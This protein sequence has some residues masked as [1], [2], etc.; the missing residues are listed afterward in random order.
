MT[1]ICEPNL[2]PAAF[3]GTRFDSH[4]QRKLERAHTLASR[5]EY[6]VVRAIFGR[7]SSDRREMKKEKTTAETSTSES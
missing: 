5:P 2:A 3:D 7:I 1:A 6:A 4:R